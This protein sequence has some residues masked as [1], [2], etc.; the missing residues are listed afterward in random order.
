[1]F[2]HPNVS[3]VTCH[4]SRVTCHV[5]RVT[6]HMSRVTCH[7]FFFFFFNFFFF[8]F[9][10]GKSGEAYRGRVCYQR[11]LPRLVFLD[12]GSAKEKATPSER[13]R[14]GEQSNKKRPKLASLNLYPVSTDNTST[15]ITLNTLESY[16]DYRTGS[17]QLITLKKI[18]GTPSTSPFC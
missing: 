6:C 3:H 8:F 18:I 10:F 13:I 5:S 4:V 9:F 15:R 11:G 17:Y 14:K 7:V 1:M 16:T 2:T 12:Q